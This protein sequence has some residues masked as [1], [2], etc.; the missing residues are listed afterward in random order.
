LFIVG[1]AH[2]VAGGVESFAVCRRFRGTASLGGTQVGDVGE[3]QQHQD[4]LKKAL[5]IPANPRPA[6]RCFSSEEEFNRIAFELL[7]ITISVFHM[8]S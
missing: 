8:L 2:V 5:G 7:G 3:F 1:G 4:I 6:R